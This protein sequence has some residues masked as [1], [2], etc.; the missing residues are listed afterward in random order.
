MIRGPGLLCATSVAGRRRRHSAW[1]LHSLR[2]SGDQTVRHSGVPPPKP[3]V[4]G[5]A[6]Q[7]RGPGA[8]LCPAPRPHPAPLPHPTPLQ[9]SS[10]RARALWDGLTGDGAGIGEEAAFLQIT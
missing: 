1:D 2:L 5:R 6:E 3:S 8:A 7:P 9:P 10:G 4:G